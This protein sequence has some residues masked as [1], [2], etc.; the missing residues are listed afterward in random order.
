MSTILR[1]KP[2]AHNTNIGC[3]SCLITLTKSTKVH[4]VLYNE[5]T[6][7]YPLIAFVHN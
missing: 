3:I 1:Y 5:C 6:T 2:L 4:F 7:A